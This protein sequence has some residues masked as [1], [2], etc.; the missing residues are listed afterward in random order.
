M[1]QLLCA[2][3]LAFSTPVWAADPAIVFMND[4]AQDVY[5]VTDVW[6]RNGEI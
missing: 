3:M 2:L 6:A 5:C 1:K 4:L